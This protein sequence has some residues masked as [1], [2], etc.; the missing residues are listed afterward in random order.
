MSA[1]AMS[2]TGLRLSLRITYGSKDK[3]PT[4]ADESAPLARQ[5]GS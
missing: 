5:M 2:P 4:F 1:V 3:R